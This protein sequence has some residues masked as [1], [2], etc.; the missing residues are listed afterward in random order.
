MVAATKPRIIL[1]DEQSMLSDMIAH[2]LKPEF[3][4]VSKVRD[5]HSLIAAAKLGPDVVVLDVNLTGVGGAD[6][7]RGVRAVSPLTK[8]LVLTMVDDRSTARSVLD[9]GASGYLLKTAALEELPAAIREVL[10][11]NTYVTPAIALKLSG[12]DSKPS[13]DA[14]TDREHQVLTLLVDGKPM[15]EVARILNLTPRTIA[16]HK[17][18][19]MKKLQVRSSAELIRTA[20][21]RDLAR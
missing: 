4:V 1:A 10:R 3:E 11:G 17:Y 6:A 20:I 5:G 16:F 2:I 8:L 12:M 13:R 7:V 21:V 19:I 14:L 15:R 18:R 9:A